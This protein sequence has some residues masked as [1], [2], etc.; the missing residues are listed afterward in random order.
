MNNSIH[1]QSRTL[2]ASKTQHHSIFFSIS[3]FHDKSRTLLSAMSSLTIFASFLAIALAGVLPRQQL[4]ATGITRTGAITYYNTGGG[5]GA[6]G[7]TLSDSGATCAV[8]TTLYDACMVPIFV[9]NLAVLGN[10]ACLPI[11]SLHH[12]EKRKKEKKARC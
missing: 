12:S 1:S 7:T 10:D 8:S 4:D 5:S 6:C 2:F 11:I 3:N 9:D